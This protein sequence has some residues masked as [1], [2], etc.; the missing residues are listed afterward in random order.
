MHVAGGHSCCGRKYIA[1]SLSYNCVIDIVYACAHAYVHARARAAHMHVQKQYAPRA[2]APTCTV[3]AL[4]VA[5]DPTEILNAMPG[6]PVH[7]GTC[8]PAAWRQ[9]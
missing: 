4:T 2:R 3:Y 1:T 8:L 5:N 6:K 9:R 7:M